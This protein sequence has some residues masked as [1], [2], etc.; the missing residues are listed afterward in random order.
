MKYPGFIGNSDES[1]SVIA[2]CE[3][4]MNWY[5]E[6]LPKGGKNSGALYPTPG[7]SEW[8]SVTDIGLRAG[9]EINGRVFAVVGGGFY[10]LFSSATSTR[11]GAVVQDSNPAQISANG[12]AGGQLFISSGNNGYCFDLTSNVL[13]LE[14]TGDCTM[15]G[16]LDGYFIAFDINTSTIRLSDLN[17]GTSWDPTQFAQRST[18]PDDWQCMVVVQ[19]PAGIWLIGSKTGEVWYDS[20]EF[21]F[22]FTLIQGAQFRFGIA[23]P[24]AFGLG[25]NRMTWLSRNDDGSGIV[26][27]AQGYS[28]QRISTYAVELAFQEYSRTATIADSEMLTYQQNGHVFNVLSFPQ[29]NATWGYDQTT[30]V[31]HQRGYWNTALMQFDFWQPRICFNAFGK[32]LVGNRMTGT[33]S[34]MDTT[35][36]TE[37]DGNAIRRVRRAPAINQE[38]YKI[39]FRRFE[40]YLQTGIGILSGQ[41]NIP[42][43]MMRTSDDG[44]QTW[45]P[46]RQASAGKMGVFYTRVY[47]QRMGAARDRVFE[48]SVSDPVPWRLIDAYLN[49]DSPGRA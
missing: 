9:L 24:F 31:W 42:I 41:G 3:F 23:A 7:F 34:E 4:T 26:V 35:F 49:N 1:Q 40:L 43:V 19:Q 18:A 8:L 32:Q 44:G 11:W 2:D 25:G 22:P 48:V 39:V 14:L 27:S 20:G 10:E 16:M 36:A 37:A 15:C 38:N 47:W 29:A 12:D 33:L 46:E 5:F 17:D 21:P 45:L 28:P 6:Q 13:T 30:G